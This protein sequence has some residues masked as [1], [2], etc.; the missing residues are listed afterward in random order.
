MLESSL[1]QTM[2]GI[3][4]VA[5][6]PAARSARSAKAVMPKLPIALFTDA[7]SDR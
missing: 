1:M 3:I 7:A 2:R 5:T 4:Y 6:G